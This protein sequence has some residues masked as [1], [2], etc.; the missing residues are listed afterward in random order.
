M[1]APEAHSGAPEHA[2]EL[3]ETIRSER[4]RYVFLNSALPIFFSPIGGTLMS[5]AL[6]E[7]TDGRRLW[8]WN[9]GLVALALVRL[10]M[11]QRFGAVISHP[12]TDFRRWERRFVGAIASIG[13]WWGV[14]A[15][16][17]LNPA[18]PTQPF[19]IFA[20]VM[21]MVGGTI[22]SYSAH[23]WCVNLAV[24]GLAV[25][26]TLWFVVQPTAVHRVLAIGSVMYMVAGLRSVRTLN[27]FFTRTYRL[28]HDVRVER[29]RAERAARSDFLT[30][31]DNRRAFWERGERAVHDAARAGAERP[32][33]VVVVDIDHF[34][35]I[36]DTHGH[37]HGDAALRVM[38][39]TL[40]QLVRK[41]D[42]CGRIGGEEFAL[43]L[44]DTTLDEART[45]A[46]RLR[47]GIR[48][49]VVA[50]DGVSFRF[51]ASFGVAALRG[52]H[53][54]LEAVLARA[55]EALYSAKQ[56]GR[57]RVEFAP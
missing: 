4:V 55:D 16:L 9:A 36:N 25:P 11:R 48:Q 49:R 13:L 2:R 42:V 7:T 12:G 23:P 6:S 21:L 30:G 14:G 19:M 29:D 35:R 52:G 57:D 24:L 3:D 39:E 47:E 20:F 31:L 45:L 43:V 51:T 28:A 56:G 33:V 17:L 53:E 18:S 26:T 5:L 50:H 41:S 34:K 10:I 46:E 15:V 40:R 22:A 1:N 44:P 37:A 54:R 38:A 27:H 8:I 32:L